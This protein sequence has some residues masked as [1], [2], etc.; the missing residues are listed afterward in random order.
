MKNLFT[1]LSILLM[2]A[3][4]FGLTSCKDDDEKIRYSI[5]GVWRVVMGEEVE[6]WEI[7]ESG[8]IIYYAY[9]VNGVLLS[10]NH[11]TYNYNGKTLVISDGGE[12]IIINVNSLSY[13]KMNLLVNNHNRDFVKVDSLPQSP[14]YIYVS[15]LMGYTFIGEDPDLGEM[16]SITFVSNTFSLNFDGLTYTGT[17]TLS[18]NTITLRYD[19][20]DDVEIISIKGPKELVYYG[21]V[22]T[23]Q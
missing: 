23:R 8:E 5:V 7:K 18:G 10:E 1:R 22:L 21:T 15:D 6:Y 14:N 11:A 19:G 12:D 3:T 17:Y 4:L 13:T 20:I 2:A 16:I 9:D